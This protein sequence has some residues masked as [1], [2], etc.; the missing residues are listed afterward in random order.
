M[1]AHVPKAMLRL[2]LLASTLALGCKEETFDYSSD[3]TASDPDDTIEAEEE[4]SVW[5][6]LTLETSESLFGAYASGAGFYVTG[7]G[8]VS[9]IRSQGEWT[10]FDIDVD[11]EDLNSLW[12]QGAGTAIEMVTVGDAG[13]V[14]TWTTDTW[15]VEDVGTPNFE[16]VS[17]I[18]SQ[19]LFA[20]GWAGVYTN[21]TGEWVYESISGNPRFNAVWYDGNFAIAVGEE[22]I[23]GFFDGQTWTLDDEITSSTLYS[24][25][26]T[27]PNNIWVVGESGTILHFDGT[28]WTESDVGTS[29]SFWGVFVPSSDEVFA[30]GNNGTALHYSSGAW[31]D[32]PTGIDNNLYAVTVSSGGSVWAVGNRGATLRLIP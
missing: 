7:T 15:V 12:G 16:G 8:G 24:V 23:I 19:D 22:G 32:L 30:V 18:S 26:G 29:V 21:R 17:G 27:S 11:D 25:H 4:E 14:G 13:N 2:G 5:D 20:V 1:T 31:T 9:A 6:D 10:L 3:D 28:G